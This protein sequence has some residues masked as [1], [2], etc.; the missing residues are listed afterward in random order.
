VKDD[1]SNI[2]RSRIQGIQAKVRGKCELSREHDFGLHLADPLSQLGQ[3]PPISS[4]RK[5]VRNTFTVF[6]RIMLAA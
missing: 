2:S 4:M 6:E 3:L 5:S 1:E